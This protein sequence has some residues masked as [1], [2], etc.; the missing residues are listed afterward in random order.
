MVRSE[1]PAGTVTADAI[2]AQEMDADVDFLLKQIPT[3][4]GE[5]AAACTI[6]VVGF[7]RTEWLA[8]EVVALVGNVRAAWRRRR[9]RWR[10]AGENAIAEVTEESADLVVTKSRL[11]DSLDDDVRSGIVLIVAQRVVETAAGAERAE[12]EVIVDVRKNDG[13]A[14]CPGLWGL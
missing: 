13:G 12:Q 9:W 7:R 3:S 11:P 6:V 14:G 5:H 10:H 8:T 1:R 2:A 4:V